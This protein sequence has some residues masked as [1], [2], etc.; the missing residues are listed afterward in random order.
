MPLRTQSGGQAICTGQLGRR[1]HAEMEGH[2]RP[3]VRTAESPLRAKDSPPPLV[4]GPEDAA[5][6][7]SSALRTGRQLSRPLSTRCTSA[8]KHQL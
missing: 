3:T 1:G 5:V 4:L 8:P 6:G 2:P 7:P